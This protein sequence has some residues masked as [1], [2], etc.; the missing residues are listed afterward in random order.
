MEEIKATPRTN[1][2]DHLANERTYLAWIRTS[3]GVM[4]LGFVVVKFSLFT[5]EIS[6]ALDVKM[7]AN[8]TGYS[9]TIGTFLVA[10]GALII[11]FA[12]FRY[13]ETKKQLD[14]GVYFH[15]TVL[16]KIATLLIFLISIL[17]LVYL[18]Q[19]GV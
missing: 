15:S 18:A 5:R 6:A 17:L 11:I 13:M 1:A 4:G 16:I 8:A 19:T 7:N 9:H 2:T 14:S 10:L 3:I 12:F